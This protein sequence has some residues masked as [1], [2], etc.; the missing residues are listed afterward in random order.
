[1]ENGRVRLRAAGVSKRYGRRSVLRGVDLTVHA[2]QVAAI[3]GANGAGKSTF[4]KI[5]AGLISPDEG[6][7]TVGGTVGYCPQQAGLFQFLRPD[8][9]FELF[10]AG[11]GAGRTASRRAGRR[12][13]RQLSWDASAPTTARHL[14]GGTQQKLNLVLSALGDP[15]LIL[16]DEPYQGFDRGS[17]T[18]FWE[19]VFRWRAEGR[20]VVVVTHMLNVLDRV[21]TV[22]DLT[23]VAV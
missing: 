1:M 7:V 16:L 14:S 13:A 19:W 2:G 4:L 6:T 21:D 22:L 9:H 15:D 3:V 17:Y 20:A 12:M 23:P 8:E 10:G 5:C 11:R 18:D